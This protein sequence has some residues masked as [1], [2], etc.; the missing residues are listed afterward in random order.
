M[1]QIIGFIL[2]VLAVMLVVFLASYF[3][4]KKS[5]V[6][7]MGLIATNMAG[8][9]AIFAYIIA[10][11][12]LGQLAWVIPVVGVISIFNFYMMHLHLSKPVVSLMKDI[13]NQLSEGDLDFSF[14][15][16]V[17]AQKNE[18][19]EIARAL[20]K[21]KTKI[22]LIVF[23]IKKISSN[24]DLSSKQQNQAALAI[25][26]SASE[27]ASSTEEISATI[28]EISS[29]NHQNAGNAQETAELSKSASISMKEMGDLAN[30]NVISINNIIEKIQVINDIAYQTN[31]LALNAAVEA[32]R[33]GEAGR[34]FAVVAN[35][36]RNL[37][38]NSKKAADEIKEMSEV[39]VHQTQQTHEFV[40]KL[41][42]EI[43]QTTELVDHI[44][45]ASLEQTTGTDQINNA[46]QSLNQVTQENAASA[47]E[48]AA[49][50]EELTNQSNSLL[51]VIGF[52]KTAE[53]EVVQSEPEEQE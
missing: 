7:I 27:Q 51:D 44:S 41:L 12:G 30:S 47:E 6:L 13:V 24:I 1:N 50:S 42:K 45:V 22:M 38:E 37:A 31:I 20:S 25:S 32:A 33:A 14:D 46:I 28:E 49:G 9:T 40:T 39:T 17:L 8:L 52:F 34:G 11:K 5:V 18:F 4:Y 53:D 48:L 36:V 3:F 19:G 21:M 23:E 35:E 43:S 15:E 26:T 10:V 2:I 16:K 29:T